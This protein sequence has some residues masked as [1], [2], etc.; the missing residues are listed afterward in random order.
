MKILVVGSGGR[1]HALAWKLSQ[2]RHHPDIFIAPG[3]AGT[4][5]AGQNVPISA[6]TPEAI[7]AIARDYLIDLVVVG[8]EQPLVA[9]VADALRENGIPVVGPSAAAAS[10]EGSKIFSKRLMEKAGI[11]TARFLVAEGPAEA[12][13]ILD[14]F[15][16][17]VVLKADGLAAGKGVIIAHSY[18]EARAAIAELME[19]RTLGDAGTRIVIEEFL[20]GEEVSFIVLTDGISVVPFPPAQDHKAIFDGDQGPNTGGMGAYCDTRILSPEMQAQIVRD[21]VH[22]TLRAM[23]AEGAPFTGFLFVGLMMTAK[24]PRVLEFNARLGDPEAQA[25]LMTLDSDLVDLCLAAARQQLAQAKVAWKPGPS[26][27]LVLAAAN[28]PGKPRTGDLIDGIGEAEAAGAT[29]FHAG[30]ALADNRITTAGGR[31]LGVTA[32]GDTLP[33]AIDSAYRAAACI[34]FDGMQKRSDIGAKG[35]K[36]W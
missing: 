24:G 19:S 29:V 15:P 7:S 11:A 34:R 21:V 30:T 32:S 36:R 18:E 1:E 8:P 13:R 2:S 20:T 3:N 4:A 9:G 31:V 10:I 14:D 6:L 22:P 17:P 33:E 27:C 5:S 28:Y 12:L 23:E 35:L 16:I 25:L 26:I